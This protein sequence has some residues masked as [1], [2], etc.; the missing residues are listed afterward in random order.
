M[1]LKCIFVVLPLTL[2][3]AFISKRNTNIKYGF[4]LCMIVRFKTVMRGKTF[5]NLFYDIMAIYFKNKN[6]IKIN[7]YCKSNLLFWCSLSVFL[8]RNWQIKS[9]EFL[10]KK[11]FNHLFGFFFCKIKVNNFYTFPLSTFIVENQSNYLGVMFYRIIQVLQNMC[12]T[13]HLLKVCV[14]GNIKLKICVKL[15]SKNIRFFY[16]F[17]C[18]Y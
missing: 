15:Y 2:L 9:W 17:F 10:L 6:L 14:I 8:V 16:I 11:N 3:Q 7:T 4:E 5:L 13:Y 1:H 12:N 18:I